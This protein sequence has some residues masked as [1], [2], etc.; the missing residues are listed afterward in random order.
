MQR[1][2]HDVIK[3]VSK[4]ITR[5]HGVFIPVSI[6]AKKNYENRSRNARFIV[7]KLLASFFPDTV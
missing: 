6:Y 3:L 1:V 5:C 4:Q 2:S 7:E